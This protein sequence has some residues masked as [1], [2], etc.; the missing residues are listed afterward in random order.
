MSGKYCVKLAFLLHQ[1]VIMTINVTKIFT[2]TDGMSV[3]VGLSLCWKGKNVVP[4]EGIFSTKVTISYDLG[5]KVKL[6]C[7]HIT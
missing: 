5:S 2:F 4:P 6:N 7:S 3:L 1:T